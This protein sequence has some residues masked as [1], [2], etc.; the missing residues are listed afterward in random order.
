M[1]EETITSD[2]VD[3]GAVTAQPVVDDGQSD[4]VNQEEIIS[5]DSDTADY[6][7]S[8]DDN[9]EEAELKDWAAKK[10]L[11]LDDPLKLAKIYR[12]AER[13]LGKRSA[14]EKQLKQAV[15]TANE[16]S[17]TDDLQALRNEVEALSFFVNHPEAKSLESE[18]VAILDQKPYLANDL[19]SVLEIAKGRAVGSSL[20]AE[21]KAGRK[22]ASEAAEKAGR[23]APP[24]V[25]ARSRVSMSKITS[26]NVDQIVAQHMGDAAWYREHQAEINT[27]LAG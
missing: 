19:E 5:Q 9:S 10:N 1:P 13:E 16:V 3:E 7:P 25:S 8:D 21:R 6:E 4:A 26:A 12:D 24:Q 11:P 2:I 23:A 15:T 20:L 18:M 14:S 27:A 22:E 17:S